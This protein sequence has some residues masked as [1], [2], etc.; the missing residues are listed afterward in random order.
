MILKG[1]KNLQK[2]VQ[3][4]AA[5]AQVEVRKAVGLDS[6]PVPETDPEYEMLASEFRTKTK[7]LEQLKRYAVGSLETIQKV[8]SAAYTLATHHRDSLLSP[9]SQT[10]FRAA[11]ALVVAHEGIID[12]ILP[13]VERRIK[14]RV[15]DPVSDE[16]VRARETLVHMDARKRCLLDVARYQARAADPATTSEDVRKATEKLDELNERTIE[17]ITALRE[18]ARRRALLFD[19]VVA[20][21]IEFHRRFYVD[22]A[23]AVDGVVDN[24]GPDALAAVRG[25][26]EDAPIE[27]RRINPSSTPPNSSNDNFGAPPSNL[28]TGPQSSSI[29]NEIDEDDDV[30]DDEAE[31]YADYA[32]SPSPTTSNLFSNDITT[33]K[34]TIFDDDIPSRKSSVFEE[35]APS[36]KGSIFDD[37]T[38][39]DDATSFPRDSRASSTYPSAG[40]GQREVAGGY[41]SSGIGQ[42]ESAGG[43]PT[44]NVGKR[45]SVGGYPSSGIG[46]RETSGAFAAADSTPVSSYP[47]GGSRQRESSYPSARA[48]TANKSAPSGPVST[49]SAPLSSR[50]S[51]GA[52]RGKQSRKTAPSI[53]GG[54]DLEGDLLGFGTGP[55]VSSSSA[56]ISTRQGR[57]KS[58][59]GG[60]SMEDL[61][62]LGG[63][64][65][66][67]TGRNATPFMRS[68]SATAMEGDLLGD[69]NAAPT[70]T[71]NTSAMGPTGRPPVASASAPNMRKAPLG[72]SNT[73]GGGVSSANSKLSEEIERER[74]RKKHE[75]EIKA[76]ADEKLAAVREREDAEI[77]EREQKDSMRVVAERK[78]D[79]WTSNGMRRGNLRAL[80]ASLDTVLYSGA[81]WKSVSMDILKENSKVKVNYHKAILQVHP[82][83]ISSKNLT[84]E[85]L[86]LA[87]LVFD[88]L[89]NGYEV[90]TAECEGRAPPPGSIGPKGSGMGKGPSGM[91]GMGRGMGRG[92]MGMG[93]MGMGG[94]MGMNGMNSGM[95]GG[96]GG[97]GGM[98]GIGGMGGM[99]GM[100][101]MS[102]GMGGMGMG[103]LNRPGMGTMP[104]SMGRR[105]TGFGNMPQGN[106]RR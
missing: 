59:T 63:M 11:D 24:I 44:T 89:K 62:D 50:E 16:L 28:D 88:E 41:P 18:A 66:S 54:G 40:V 1:M 52:S 80:L 58:N 82:D 49:T 98:G 17:L 33:Q 14:R 105:G 35:D 75:A 27:H 20:E 78:V 83:K 84:P 34:K 61:L 45:E 65:S 25:A 97:M 87:E 26:A 46:H 51:D 71:R 3:R 10:P 56:S 4:T 21:T 12:N 42:R 38:P 55:D 7:D 47:T 76:R 68:S 29:W 86:V 48:R 103:G 77:R 53:S 95:G 102:R 30:D 37:V 60:S 67:S 90:W 99:G 36:R 94:G 64:E 69:L 81:T 96:M 70:R 100:N 57:A 19:R 2:G 32:P 6:A 39:I 93:G 85:Q 101:G 43:Y 13:R 104:G 15:I 22:A 23:R 106:V 31:T 5:R 74:L 72:G 92:G 73:E 79:Q 8:S 9:P 91:G